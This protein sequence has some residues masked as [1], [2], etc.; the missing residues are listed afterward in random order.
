MGKGLVDDLLERQKLTEE[1]NEAGRSQHQRSVTVN[2]SGKR[3]P[4]HRC[5]L[6]CV[7]NYPIHH[8]ARRG[9]YMELKRLLSEL[10]PPWSEEENANSAAPPLGE[11]EETSYPTPSS[12]SRDPCWALEPDECLGRTPLHYAAYAGNVEKGFKCT[13]MILEAISLAVRPGSLVQVLRR[14]VNVVDYNHETALHLAA[15]NEATMIVKELLVN[16]ADLDV[17]SVDG[18]CGLQEIYKRTPEAMNDALCHSISYVELCKRFKMAKMGMGKDE[19]S[20]EKKKGQSKKLSEPKETDELDFSKRSLV[21]ICLNFYPL[22]GA[23]VR[24]GREK[25]GGPVPETIFLYKINRK[26]MASDVRRQILTNVLVQSF[27]HFKWNKVKLFC[28][29]AIFFHIIWLALYIGIVIDVFVLSCP[30]KANADGNNDTEKEYPMMMS[31]GSCEITKIVHF[32]SA[33]LLIMSA[34]ICL[35]EVFQF[36]RLRTLYIR[37]ENMAQCILLTFIFLSV[38]NLYLNHFSVISPLHYQLSAFGIFLAWTLFLCQLAKLPRVCIRF[39]I[40]LFGWRGHII[41]PDHGIYVEILTR[42]F[43]NFL[44]FITIFSSLLISFVFSFNILLPNSTGFV[45]LSNSVLK[46]LTMMTGELNYDDIFHSEEEQLIYPISSHVMYAIFIMVATI[47]L[48][49]L[50]IGF[51]VSDIQGLQK[52]AEVNQISNKLEQIFLM[53]CFLLSKPMQFIFEVW[54]KLFLKGDDGRAK[55]LQ[56]IMVTRKTFCHTWMCYHAEMKELPADHRVQIR[57]WA[58]KNCLSKYERLPKIL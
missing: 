51:T 24:D 12:Q 3:K 36:I 8:A 5:T 23:K 37:F 42:V 48:F 26:R 1:S 27:L 13:R 7:V 2:L 28:F 33:L 20:D 4:D 53:E 38:P 52:D 46:V 6:N 19:D 56:G 18:K 58:S 54:G 43:K 55:I 31:D 10:L 25:D 16:H 49:N 57:N 15:R 17:K 40:S 14:L 9:G 47:I 22:L 34:C 39:H 35:K 41:L 21:N 30:R 44:I 29:F 11:E 45:N 50:L 32:T